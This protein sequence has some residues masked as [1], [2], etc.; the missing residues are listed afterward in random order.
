[1]SEHQGTWIKGCESAH[2]VEVFRGSEWK[3]CNNEPDY[4]TGCDSGACVEV[5][6]LRTVVKIR[7]SKDPDGPVLK[8]DLEEWENFQNAVRR[9]VF[10]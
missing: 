6:V 9:G 5:K 7:D 10:D 8:F 4:K 1:M 3:C 2:C